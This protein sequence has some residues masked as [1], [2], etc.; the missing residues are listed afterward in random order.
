MKKVIEYLNNE[1]KQNIV[2]HDS[3]YLGAWIYEKNLSVVCVNINNETLQ[4]RCKID[5]KYINTIY[6]YLQ[7]YKHIPQNY[8][9]SKK[10]NNII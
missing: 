8:F 9:R 3:K 7:T 10:L 5:G 2:D 4:L 6:G 1:F